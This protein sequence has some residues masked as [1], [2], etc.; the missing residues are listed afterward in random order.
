MMILCR[1]SSEIDSEAGTNWLMLEH[2]VAS[3]TWS[4]E[5]QR[6]PTHLSLIDVTGGLIEAEAAMWI[7]CQPV[8]GQLCLNGTAVDSWG[9]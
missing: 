4:A 6:S 2:Q 8:D 5:V 9:Q 3:R 1:R 7:S